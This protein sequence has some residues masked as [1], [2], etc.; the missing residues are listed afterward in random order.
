[1]TTLSPN[2]SYITRCPADVQ[3][4]LQSV[5]AAIRAAA[6]EAEEAM[7]YGIPTFKLKG[8]NLVHFGAF[9][10]HIGFYPTPGAIVEFQQEFSGYKQA[11]GSVQFPLDQPMPLAL[12][13]KVVAYRLKILKGG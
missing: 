10:H 11:K 9:A 6:P 12:I 1:M 4:V 5:R 8:K 3:K 7:A 13:K 2:D